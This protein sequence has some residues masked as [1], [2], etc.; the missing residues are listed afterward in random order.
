MKTAAEVAVLVALSLSL[1]STL[2]ACL[3]RYKLRL[4][5]VARHAAVTLLLPLTALSRDRLRR[6]MQA[7][8]RQTLKPRRLVLAVESENDPVFHAATSLALEHWCYDVEVVVAGVSL[9]CSQKCFNLIAA[10][11]RARQ[12]DDGLVL[13]DADVEPLPWWL[14]ALVSPLIDGGFDV[15]TGYRWPVIN[16]NAV[17]GAVTAAID[18][19]IAVLPRPPRM[20]LAWGGSLALSRRACCKLSLPRILERTLSD[21]LA[22]AAAA[23]AL[24]LRVLN[25]RALLVPTP[26]QHS[27]R[28]AWSF[29]RR[30]YT[31]V[32]VYRPWLWLLALLALS[33]LVISWASIL[34]SLP[35][36]NFARTALL[37]FAALA[38]GKT[39]ALESIGHG[40]GLRESPTARMSQYALVVLKPLVDLFHLSI[41]VASAQPRILKWAHVTYRI[42]GPDR[43]TVT[44]RRPWPD[45]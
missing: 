26:I 39:L 38:L 6:L 20:A 5:S 16:G 40:L 11:T 34:L 9:H 21:D 37:L 4:P 32:R 3:Y 25:R 12:Q 8:D 15:V 24:D 35:D 42:R 28:S 41:I 30:Q 18:R 31:I 10:Y 33:A 43:I 1:L 27:L 14:S 45:S 23:S 36:P 19:S 22:I 17:G 13:L 44:E 2:G 7:L 29:G